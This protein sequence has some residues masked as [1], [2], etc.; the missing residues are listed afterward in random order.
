MKKLLLF[1]A[2]FYVV[3]ASAKGPRLLENEFWYVHDLIIDGTSSIPPTTV[4][5]KFSINGKLLFRH[6]R[7]Q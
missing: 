1:L 4:Y 5:A 6:E 7:H 3:S 2:L